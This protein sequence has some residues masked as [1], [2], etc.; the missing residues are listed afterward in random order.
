VSAH[1][2]WEILQR[3]ADSLYR[4][5]SANGLPSFATLFNQPLDQQR[6]QGPPSDF[7][8]YFE[9]LL[10]AQKFCNRV[11]KTIFACTD[12]TGDGIPEA[13]V[14]LLEDEFDAVEQ[15]LCRN[16]TGMRRFHPLP[17]TTFVL[18]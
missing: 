4:V 12:G 9:V 5:A 2:S 11:S 14:R 6:R 8:A 16:Q 1:S 15:T 13:T 17:H 7:L 18:G 10:E 3:N